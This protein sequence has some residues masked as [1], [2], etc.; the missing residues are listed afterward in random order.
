M[1]PEDDSYSA[2]EAYRL[3][4]KSQESLEPLKGLV[5]EYQQ[6]WSG[7]QSQIYEHHHLETTNERVFSALELGY[8]IVDDLLDLQTDIPS[9]NEYR[10]VG[11]ETLDQEEIFS[12]TKEIVDDYK[13]IFDE[14][15][16][17]ATEIEE[18][19]S[20]LN[21]VKDRIKEKRRATAPNSTVIN[22]EIRDS[23]S[24]FEGADIKK[25]IELVFTD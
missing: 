13:S 25:A 6:I 10:A 15:L 20:D 12:E 4:S 19:E 11:N 7:Y 22:N 21:P 16:K 14:L 23:L 2:E 3:L 17:T 1:V 5:N 18:S 8:E 24:R 9:I